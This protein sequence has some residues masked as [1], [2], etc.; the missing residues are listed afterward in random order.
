MK[1]YQQSS[2]SDSLGDSVAYL[3]ERHNDRS[4]L[5]SDCSLEALLDAL[6]FSAAR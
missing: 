3:A 2:S 5:T 1:A 4:G 6:K